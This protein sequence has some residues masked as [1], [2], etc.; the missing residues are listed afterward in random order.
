MG[1]FHIPKAGDKVNVRG[2][3]IVIAI[4]AFMVLAAIGVSL[5]K[6]V[7]MSSVEVARQKQLTIYKDADF[8][9]AEQLANMNQASLDDYIG[10]LNYIIRISDSLSVLGRTG[11]ADADSEYTVAEANSKLAITGLS[12]RE[13][14]ARAKALQLTG[15]KQT[16]LVDSLYLL[17]HKPMP[18]YPAEAALLRER[19]LSFE[20]YVAEIFD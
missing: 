8:C 3:V 19:N 4:I 5:F 20:R 17:V 10:M 11:I 7:P 18:S 2:A 14:A 12:Q 1:H 16:A 6:P 15:K 9:S 13:A